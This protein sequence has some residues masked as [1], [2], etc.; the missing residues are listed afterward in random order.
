M[1]QQ[2]KLITLSDGRKL[3]YI[4]YGDL[5][6]FPIFALHGLPGSRLWFPENDDVSI[7][8]GIR[9][10]TVD[11]PGFGNSDQLTNRT[12]PD[13]SND[14]QELSQSLG[15]QKYSVFG[16]SGGGVY[17]AACA[18]KNAPSI[19]KCGLISTVNQFENGRPPR[20]MASA[21]RNIFILAKRFPWGL[22]FMLNQQKNFIQRRPEK[23]IEAIMSGTRHLSKSDK[24]IMRKKEN[25]EFMLRHVKE[26][27]K[28]GVEGTVYEAQLFCRDWGF[29]VKEIKAPVEV[30]HGTEDTL[31][32]IGPIKELSQQLR[33]CNTNFIEGKGHFLTEE[34]DI[35]EKIL[36][37]LKA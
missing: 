20:E 25:A 9:L 29:K 28:N 26:A 5:N 14:L 37:S 7:A 3:G 15:I 18:L 30:W 35:W 2:D 34:N 21:N 11:R 33:A 19:H 31:A 32:P 1:K 23:Y 22:K 24:R 8:H 4:E 13:F 12:F 17:A 27:Y 10:I 16:V 36:M 6:G